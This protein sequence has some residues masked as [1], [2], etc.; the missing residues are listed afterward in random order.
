[1]RKSDRERTPERWRELLDERDGDAVRL[2]E[3]SAELYRRLMGA[4]DKLITAGGRLEVLELAA[5]AHTVLVTTAQYDR[6]FASG[7]ASGL[8]EA[9]DKALATLVREDE[10]VTDA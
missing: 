8:A 10:E 7:R 2:R 1:M 5:E 4:E 9:L 6:D 3:H